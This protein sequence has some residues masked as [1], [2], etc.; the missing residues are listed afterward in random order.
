MIDTDLDR[1]AAEAWTRVEYALFRVLPA[2]VPM[3]RPPATDAAIDAVAAEL[4][5]ALPADFRASLRV[6]DGTGYQPSAVPLDNLYSTEEIVEAT[7]MWRDNSDD[8]PLWTDP[9][10]L[11]YLIDKGELRASGPVRPTLSAENRVVVGTMNGDVWWLLDLD[12]PAGGTPG[13]VVRVDPE[14]GTWDVL[15]PSWTDLLHRYADDLERFA[16]DPAT[17]A[18][19]INEEV[20][21][22]CEWGER[23]EATGVRPEWLRHV[24]ARNPYED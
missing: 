23:P 6:H 3:L 15:A 7:G 14:C 9:G 10:V 4:G 20:G 2:A 13:Q 17:S 11:A 16:A 22:A 21:P 8:D 5:L 24:P 1:A 18:L 19:K 12:P